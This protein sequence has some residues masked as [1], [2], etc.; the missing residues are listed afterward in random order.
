MTG[1]DTKITQNPRIQIN[2]LPVGRHTIQLVVE[3]DQGIRSTSQAVT[4]TVGQ[5]SKRPTAVVKIVGSKEVTAGDAL[6]LSA[7]GSSAPNGA[8]EQYIW[9]WQPEAKDR[10][11]P[12]KLNPVKK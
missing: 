7:K 11:R 12:G 1:T 4:V 10:R 3:D 6:E 5:S 8:I 9:T 2:D